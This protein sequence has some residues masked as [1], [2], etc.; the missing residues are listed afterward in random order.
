MS[1]LQ[2]RERSRGES[3]AIPEL[4]WTGRGALLF[5]GQGAQRKGMG[6]ELVS[7]SDAAALV[8]TTAEGVI[9]GISTI[10]FED[11]NGE[12]GRTDIGQLASGVVDV[13]AAAA[14]YQKF[15][16]LMETP[17]VVGAG[18]SFGEL[19]NLVVSGAL[20]FQKYLEFVRDRGSIMQQVGDKNPGRMIAVPFMP[21]E[22]VSEICE[23]TGVYP[24]IFYPGMTI[25]SG[26]NAKIDR[27]LEG[28]RQSGGKPRETGV[29]YAFH[30]P[31]MEEA[32]D[33]IEE[34]LQHIS[35]DVPRYPVALSAR[36]IVTQDVEQIRQG[37]LDQITQP[38]YL[39]RTM[40]Q[41]KAI[42]AQVFI[43][44]CPQPVLSKFLERGN[45]EVTAVSI[46]DQSSLNR[47]SLAFAL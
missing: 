41:M 46:H 38:A 33:R 12:L 39:P 31:L 26:S 32:R 6:Q 14:L 29:L 43:E 44:L 45:P 4:L 27:A 13:A 10:C 3:L 18:I 2:E 8:F 21:E 36:G 35:I 25:V 34:Y 40:A 19:P 22:V 17:P 7:V 5:P 42:G 24:A 47:L 30:T 23:E 28:I 9:P 15:P 16:Q 20:E 11:P 1:G 37:L